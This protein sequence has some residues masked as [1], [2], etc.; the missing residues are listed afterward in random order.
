MMEAEHAPSPEPSQV[1]GESGPAENEAPKKRT[2]DDSHSSQEES[3]R[4]K[5][6]MKLICEDGWVT[7]L[8]KGKSRKAYLRT[9][10]EIREASGLE[11]IYDV[12][13]TNVCQGLIIHRPETDP[14]SAV[15][16]QKKKASAKKA[17]PDYK[18]FRK[19][20]VAGLTYQPVI[21]MVSVAPKE[22]EVSRHSTERREALEIQQRRADELFRDPEPRGSSKRS[23]R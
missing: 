21:R 9:K 18:A 14:G 13:P 11:V 10:K 7:R 19:N 20:S 5:K 17:G 2:G 16:Q 1:E 3:G 8:P 4:P 22:V 6:R 12:A 15:A 23:R